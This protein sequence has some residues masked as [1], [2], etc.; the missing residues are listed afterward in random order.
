MGLE[1]E[2]SGMKK[3]TGVQLRNGSYVAYL[4]GENGER[5]RRAIGRV[6]ENT[7]ILTRNKWALELREGKYVKPLPRKAI[8]T[9]AAIA[10]AAVQHAK[11]YQRTWD[12]DTGRAAVCKEWWGKMPAASITKEMIDTKLLER[13]H[14]GTWSETT[15]N[16][17]R[18]WIVRCYN[19]AIERGE[20]GFNPALK[21]HRYDVHNGRNRPLKDEEEPLL[22]AA[23]RELYPSKEVELDLLLHLGARVSNLFGIAKSRRKPMPPLQWE[24]VDMAWKVV[25]FP[26][27]KGGAGYQIPLNAVAMDALNELLKR[28][29]EG[30]VGPVV[31]RPDGIVLQ[32]C[33]RWF[34]KSCE[35]A[36]IADMRIH[37]LRHTFGTRLRRNRVALEDIAALMG[38]DLATNRMTQRYAHADLDTL[39]AAVASLVPAAETATTTA[40]KTATSTISEIRRAGSA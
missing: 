24:N 16:E 39:R 17:Y 27:S 14:A 4:T 32:S 7:A 1:S 10:D 25:T 33:R 11:D 13:V 19:L 6:S 21:A 8:V 37:D 40:T 12:A 2:K 23:I 22:R 34:E 5:I 26:R 20:V 38:H 35:K 9:F 29:P 36:G 18:V 28:S 30:K 3:N 31:R 15:S